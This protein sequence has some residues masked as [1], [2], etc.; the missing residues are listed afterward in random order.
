MDPVHAPRL[1]RGEVRAVVEGLHRCADARGEIVED[2]GLPRGQVDGAAL[3]R[4]EVLEELHAV[5][6]VG[7]DDARAGDDHALFV[8][9]VRHL[10]TRANERRRRPLSLD[11]ANNF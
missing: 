9:E 8:R 4:Q 7:G 11:G 1:L 3:A 10:A 6:A 5:V 2:A